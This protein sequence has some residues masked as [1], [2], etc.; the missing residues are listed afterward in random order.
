LVGMLGLRGVGFKKELLLLVYVFGLVILRL[1]LSNWVKIEFSCV[2]D[3]FLLKF[4]LL[5]SVGLGLDSALKDRS[6]RL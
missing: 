5:F 6:V 1:R 2:F 4:K 3:A